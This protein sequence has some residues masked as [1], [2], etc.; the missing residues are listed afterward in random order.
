MRL[1]GSR[2]AA[3]SPGHGSLQHVGDRV[4]HSGRAAEKLRPGN[5]KHHLQRLLRAR[6]P[7]YHSWVTVLRC[8]REATG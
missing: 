3:K 6:S 7:Y 5:L 2:M 1:R 4:R 8:A